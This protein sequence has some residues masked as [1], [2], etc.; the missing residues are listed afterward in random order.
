MSL[1]PFLATCDPPWTVDAGGGGRGAQNHYPLTGVDGIAHVMRTSPPWRDVGPGL[2][3]MWATSSAF[4][5]GNAHLLAHALGFRPCAGFVWA[6]VDGHVATMG[7]DECGIP[8]VGTLFAP[9]RRMG[10]GQWSRCE[11]EHLLLCR[12][13]DVKVPPPGERR[14]SVIYA[15]RSKHSGKPEAAWGVIEQVSRASLGPDVVGV[16]YFARTR[17]AGWHAFGRLD[18]EDKPP[19]WE[20]A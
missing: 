17:R 8:I 2:L 9:P 13:G 10:L 16:E 6:K 5:T 1:A 7:N 19:R 15:L 4:V 3:W 12:R 20:A 14:R 11:H 18:G